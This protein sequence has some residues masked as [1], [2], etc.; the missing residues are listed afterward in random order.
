MIKYL[1]QMLYFTGAN[2]DA[3][4]EKIIY[5]SS[6][7]FFLFISYN[8]PCFVDNPGRLAHSGRKTEEE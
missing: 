2:A 6:Q 4:R 3:G 5:K 8:M 1:I 7:A